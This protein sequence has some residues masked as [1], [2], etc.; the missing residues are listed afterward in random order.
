LSE[1]KSKSEQPTDWYLSFREREFYVFFVDGSHV[2]RRFLKKGFAHCYVI[3]K[4][5]FLWLMYDPTRSGLQSVI[6]PCDIDT[7]VIDLMLEQSPTASVVQLKSKI[8]E[9]PKFLRPRALTCVSVLEYVF[10]FYTGAVT[11]YGLYKRLLSG[12]HQAIKE[13]R[14][15]VTQCAHQD[16]D[17]TN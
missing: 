9:E 5:E 2:L 14:P 17:A 7:P 16:A 13:A 10:G 11:P 15:W 6:L 3:E 12:K 1:S 4:L 8:V